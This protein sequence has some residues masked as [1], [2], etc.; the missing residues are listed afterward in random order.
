M[1]K[2]GRGAVR[3]SWNERPT[4]AAGVTSV[5]RLGAILAGLCATE[6]DAHFNEEEILLALEV[7]LQ[8]SAVGAIMSA[9]SNTGHDRVVWT[10]CGPNGA[11]DEW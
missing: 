6:A 8:A 5:S 3:V 7:S 1:L 4:S 11:A 2:A 9:A 10:I